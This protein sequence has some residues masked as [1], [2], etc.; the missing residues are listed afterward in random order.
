MTNRRGFLQMLVA[1]PAAAVAPISPMPQPTQIVTVL[2]TIDASGA[3]KDR[4]A[5][6]AELMRKQRAELLC[7]L[8]RGRYL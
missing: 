8:R 7:D 5:E 3:I 1:S 6:L 2:T 4:Y